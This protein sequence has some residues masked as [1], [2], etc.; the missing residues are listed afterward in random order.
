MIASV[1]I[2]Y[3]IVVSWFVVVLFCSSLHHVKA[4]GDYPNP[5]DAPV[6]LQTQM[7]HLFIYSCSLVE[8]EN[9]LLSETNLVD[10]PVIMQTQIMHLI[11]CLIERRANII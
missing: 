4:Q 8:T 6:I 5:V 9:L 3:N 10:V 1:G 7:M 2:N 11:L